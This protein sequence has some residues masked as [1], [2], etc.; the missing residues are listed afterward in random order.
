MAGDPADPDLSTLDRIV[1]QDT[2]RGGDDLIAGNGG[3]DL[4]LG[5]TGSDR[6]SGGAD[7]DIALGDF[8]EVLLV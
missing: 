2:D 3:N 5:G 7:H 8:G 1:T 6:I 4:I